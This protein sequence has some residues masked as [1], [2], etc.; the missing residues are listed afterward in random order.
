MSTPPT[1]DAEA[2]NGSALAADRFADEELPPQPRTSGERSWD[3]LRRPGWIASHLF[4]VTVI[5]IMVGL[6]FWQ[7]DRLDQRRVTNAQVAAQSEA[8]PVSIE[9]GLARPVAEREFTAIT[10][11]GRFVDPEIVRVAN[12]SQGGAAGDWVVGLYRTDAGLYV[13]VNRGFLTREEVAAEPAAGPLVGWLRT[14]QTKSSAL[15]GT[16]TGDTFRVPRLDVA[17]IMERAFDADLIDGPVAPMWVEMAEPDRAFAAPAQSVGEPVLPEPVP[18]P[19]LDEGSHLS[20][21]MQWFTFSLMGA[22]VYLLILQ[23]KA[24]ERSE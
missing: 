22:F 13:L 4:A 18:L 11:T 24:G 17:A 19:P 12:R 14:S 23:R 21:A 8:N 1:V 3:F 2:T 16:D 7:L 10:D 15:G 20:Y 5:V 6:G 9:A